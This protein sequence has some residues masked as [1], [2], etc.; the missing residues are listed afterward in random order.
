V[1][2]WLAIID[3]GRLALGEAAFGKLL[4]ERQLGSLHSDR[5]LFRDS[6]ARRMVGGIDP[7]PPDRGRRRPGTTS[8]D[9]RAGR[10]SPKNAS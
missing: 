6:A 7:W 1:P 10:G 4:L 2:A 9:C 8:L 5:F 3:R